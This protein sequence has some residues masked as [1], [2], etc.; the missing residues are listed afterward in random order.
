MADTI[1]GLKVRIGADLTEFRKVAGDMQKALKPVQQK[2]ADIGKSMTTY[3][4][5]P[6]LGVA[7][8]SVK[9]A[10]DLEQAQ[11][12][13]AVMLGS[14]QKAKQ[15][16]DD[17]AKFGASTPFEFRDLIG[18]SQRM[19]AFGFAADQV[20]PM[21]TTIGDASAG[22]AEKIQRITTA[23]GQIRAKGK[24]STE[25][26]LQLTE[27]GIPA[28]EILQEK[29]HLTSKQMG[30]L[31]N[32]GIKA[33]VAIK[34]LL[35]GLD[36]R[37]GGTMAKSANNI[38]LLFSNVFDNL[39]LLAMDFGQVLIEAFDLKGV[40]QAVIDGLSKLRDV[41]NDLRENHP[42]LL[43]IGL[44]IGALAAAA[45][46]LL[47]A[48][49]G[50][51]KFIPFLKAGFLLM[52]GPIGITVAAV[53]ALAGA[54]FLIYKNW[55]PISA[56]FTGLWNGIT[57]VV[58]ASVSLL[59]E[60][61]KGLW[62]KAQRFF[63]EG[64]QKLIA[65]LEQFARWIGA[66]GL[67]DSIQGFGASLGDLIPEGAIAANEKRVN[68][69]K[70]SLIGASRD[71]T[72]LLTSTGKELGKAAADM[73]S[74]VAGAI[75]PSA[76]VPDAG[77]GG[78][79][80]GQGAASFVA[81]LTH[82]F[83]GL[84]AA[85][86]DTIEGTVI[87]QL[88][89]MREVAA[90]ALTPL[91]ESTQTIMDIGNNAVDGLTNAIAGAAA[92]F[93]NFGRAIKR[94]M[95]MVVADITAAITKALILK[96]LTTIGL[97]LPTGGFGGFIGSVLMGLGGARAMG[98]PVLSGKSYLVGERGP[99]LFTPRQSGTIVPNHA[100]ASPPVFLPVARISMGD[101][102]FAIEEYQRQR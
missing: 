97:A 66:E 18:A 7:A 49:S 46:P 32:A 83:T 55:K 86:L 27:A 2:L 100:L 14:G 47:L 71:L 50:I 21:L 13:F 28:F 87:P 4:T 22:S 82:G 44:A 23:L 53:T 63:L 36:E 90:V 10:G 74:K 31:G 70:T 1:N 98:G 94:V 79:G 64:I 48:F 34:A 68:E 73:A 29:L 54:A 24:V 69:L 80:S 26:V 59:L 8:A 84:K 35:E 39:S 91:S 58:S 75:V 42:V 3:V 17:L 101:L 88:V 77:A 45:G 60:T 19:L 9:L 62:P 72:A 61:I 102:V 33:D 25:E 95:Q 93:E 81:Q 41:L 38:N 15:F 51:A 12:N 11:T 65:P 99:E 16:L 6:L 5:L 76:D 52:T 20:I 57:A 67:A 78:G 43:R 96:A 56:F 37:F 89:T 30:N 40:A 85:A 92:G